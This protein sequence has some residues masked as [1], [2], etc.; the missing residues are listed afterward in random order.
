MAGPCVTTELRCPAWTAALPPVAARRRAS[1][2]ERE[3]RNVRLLLVSPRKN[4]RQALRFPHFPVV[5][6]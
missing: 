3:E 6:W 4:C 1:P 2:R 5:A